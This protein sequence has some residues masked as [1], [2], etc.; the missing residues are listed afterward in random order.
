MN[1][2][3]MQAAKR[4]MIE[5]LK[6]PQELGKEPEQIRYA[7]TFDLYGMHYYLFK[8]KRGRM[9]KWL[10]G[11]SGGFVEDE[12]E[13][14]G[15]V[16]SEMQEYHEETARED[17]IVL[18]ETVRAYWKEQAERGEQQK[19]NAGSFLA[20]VLLERTVWDKEAFKE[21]LKNEW[22]IEETAVE[23]LDD[24]VKIKKEVKEIEDDLESLEEELDELEKELARL[25]KMFEEGAL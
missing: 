20:F 12:L 9:G 2:I 8:Y 13:N 23:D 17:A 10:L 11:V 19:E 15:H 6:H 3:Q 18:I 24:V 14:C 21:Q 25:E 1:Q 4:V 16:Y 7:G 22:E 5:W